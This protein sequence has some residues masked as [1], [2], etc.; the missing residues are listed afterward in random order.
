MLP[1][2]VRHA[3]RE[4]RT[5]SS[6]RKCGGFRFHP[7]FRIFGGGSSRVLSLLEGY[8]AKDIFSRL[9]SAMLVGNRIPFGML[10]SSVLRQ[11]CFG[12]R[13]RNWHQLRY[14][15]RTLKPGWWTCIILCGSWAVWTERNAR[16]HGETTRSIAQ[17]VKWAI[18]VATDLAVTG[19]QHVVRVNKELQKWKPQ[20]ERF[21]KVNVDAAFW[22]ETHEGGT[23]AGLQNHDGKLLRA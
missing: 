16:N 5:R 1:D 23:G 19:S 6:G 22:G 2:K 18:D 8:Y 9:I 11:E 4:D 21:T 20:E 13:S 7:K 3:S 17:S 10:Y 12:K 15:S 14:R